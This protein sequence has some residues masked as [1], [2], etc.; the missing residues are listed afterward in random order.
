[1]AQNLATYQANPAVDYWEGYNEPGV[2]SDTMAW[3]AAF[4]AER[5]RVM[6][7]YGLKAAIGAFSTGVPEWEQ[8]ADFLPAI[9]AAKQYGGI[10]TLHEYDAPTMDRSYGSALP[11][12]AYYANR[13]S[14]TFRY[15][16]WYEDF[17]K[18]QGLVIPLVISEAGVDGLVH[19]RPGPEDARGW[20]DFRSY[21]RDN[22]LGDDSVKEYLRQL[23]WYDA[24]MQKDAYVIGCT[25][26][27]AGPMNDDWESYDITPILR[28]IAT[29]IIVP[30]K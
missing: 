21:W 18:P 24:E 22:G 12:Q 30:Q 10:L 15:R 1:M 26:F 4:E 20:Y 6:A 17:L 3:Y 5:C 29:Y 2:G 9:R 11:N 27:T 8:F 28:H 13:G 16:W 23:S 19:N 14:L 7:Q 25:V